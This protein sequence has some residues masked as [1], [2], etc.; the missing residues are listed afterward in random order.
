MIKY[1]SVRVVFS[2]EIM[3]DSWY[4]YIE[5]Y[6]RIDKWEEEYLWKW[7]T[8]DI[9]WEVRMEYIDWKCILWSHYWVYAIASPWCSYVKEARE[10]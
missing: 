5:L 7:D 10:E 1:T 2:D 6:G 9:K 4:N 3:E 8:L